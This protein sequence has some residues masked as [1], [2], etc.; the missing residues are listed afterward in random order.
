[1]LLW[2]L[3]WCGFRLNDLGGN[4]MRQVR[5][6]AGLLMFVLLT[7]TAGANPS[8][9][10]SISAGDKA[11]FN[12]SARYDFVAWGQVEQFAIGAWHTGRVVN[13][14]ALFKDAS[15]FDQD[16]SGWCVALIADEPP[17][18]ADE[19]VLRPEHHPVWG[20]CPSPSAP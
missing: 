14:W 16:L 2:N 9:G 19:V 7:G 1:M 10:L 5:V 3:F 18:F 20:T 15:S 8:I 11:A 17:T 12:V 6:L 4:L 13:M